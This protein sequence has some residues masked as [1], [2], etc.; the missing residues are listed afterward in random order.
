MRAARNHRSDARTRRP[1]RR[2][3]LI[4]LGRSNRAGG[5]LGVMT[6]GQGLQ[7]HAAKI[8]VAEDA[9]YV[10]V[11]FERLKECERSLQLVASKLE[12]GLRSHSEIDVRHL[13][14]A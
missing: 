13:C 11:L 3:S 4:R 6:S 1:P 12:L 10:L 8:Q 7:R 9:L 5:T 14:G 2:R